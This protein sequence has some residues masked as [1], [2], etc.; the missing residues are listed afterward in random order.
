LLF[1]Q[2]SKIFCRGLENLPKELYL[3]R[4]L[5]KLS[6]WIC[7][8]IYI[9]ACSTDGMVLH[10]CCLLL[11][12]YRIL[13]FFNIFQL[14][15]LVIWTYRYFEGGCCTQVIEPSLIILINTWI[16]H[17]LIVKHMLIVGAHFLVITPWTRI[18]GTFFHRS[19]LTIRKLSSSLILNEALHITNELN[20]VLPLCKSS[21]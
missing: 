18:I 4:K 3:V 20:F 15:G 13:V 9:L 14:I 1:H 21:G 8:V 16:S 12:R 17:V 10:K 11:F 7:K 5:F 6:L 2:S 19:P